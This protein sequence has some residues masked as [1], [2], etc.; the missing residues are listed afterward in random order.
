MH[1]L[2]VAT[3]VQLFFIAMVFAQ[4]ERRLMN[5]AYLPVGVAI[6]GITCAAMVLLLA[7]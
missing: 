1:A 7:Q 3:L 2:T 4:G 5:G 6:M